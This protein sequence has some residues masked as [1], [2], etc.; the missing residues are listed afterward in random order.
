[1]D[2]K[3]CSAKVQKKSAEKTFSDL[4]LLLRPLVQVDRLDFGDVDPEISMNTGASYADKDAQVPRR[5]SRTCK[6][7][8]SR[9][10]VVSGFL[11]RKHTEQR[12]ALQED[13][14]KN[15]EGKDPIIFSPIY[16]PVMPET[17]ITRPTSAG[18]SSNPASIRQVS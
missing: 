8:P 4:N 10:D 16:R 5:P 12:K 14:L 18:N 1:M 2:L 17:S 13:K 6:R 7:D 11:L 15:N 3:R 9:R